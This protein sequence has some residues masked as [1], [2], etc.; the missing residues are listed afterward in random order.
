MIAK[1][2]NTQDKDTSISNINFTEL[3]KLSQIVNL[4]Y[5]MIRC[6]EMIFLIQAWKKVRANAGVPGID[7]Q[8]FVHIESDMGVSA[9]LKEIKDR[10]ISKIYKR[11]HLLRYNCAC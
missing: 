9:F 10:L 5:F 4:V 8:T 6:I 2:I 3:P 1:A 11:Q 7:E